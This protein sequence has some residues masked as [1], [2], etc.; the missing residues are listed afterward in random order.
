MLITRPNNASM[1]GAQSKDRL[2]RAHADTHLEWNH[3]FATSADLSTTGSPIS[4]KN[5]FFPDLRLSC[6]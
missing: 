1:P 2:G 5:N 4:S 6:R 3:N